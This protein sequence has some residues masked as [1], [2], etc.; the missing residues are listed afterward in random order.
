[1]D[2]VFNPCA[3]KSL[4]HHK[5]VQSFHSDIVFYLLH[6]KHVLAE[7]IIFNFTVRYPP[8]PKTKAIDSYSAPA[9]GQQQQQQQQQQQ[10]EMTSDVTSEFLWC[11]RAFVLRSGKEVL[12]V[13]SDD[14]PDEALSCRRRA[15]DVP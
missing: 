6:C 15:W 13:A 8:S 7:L 1:M 12:D 11:C 14:P 4:H 2:L 9:E 3:P 5:I 10:L